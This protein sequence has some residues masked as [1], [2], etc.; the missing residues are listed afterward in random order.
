MS[1]KKKKVPLSLT[2]KKPVV[3]TAHATDIVSK[4]LAAGEQPDET[5]I[6]DPNYATKELMDYAFKT[7]AG[8]IMNPMMYFLTR[9]FAHHRRGEKYDTGLI[10]N[11]L[12][13]LSGGDHEGLLEDLRAFGETL[14]TELETFLAGQA[15]K[16]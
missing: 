1:T 13:Q 14:Q 2:V 15:A 3:V 6:D 16:E 12:M 7:W 5:E 11:Q 8:T 9:T 4:D 10:Y